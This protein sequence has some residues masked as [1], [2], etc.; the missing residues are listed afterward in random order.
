MF[1]KLLVPMK[2]NYTFFYLLN[3]FENIN[4][5]IKFNKLFDDNFNEF[6]DVFELLDK[7]EFEPEKQIVK[8]II[9]FSKSYDVIK[10]KSSNVELNLN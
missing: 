9:D 10:L 5:L 7:A 2:K 1:N 8:K 6:C 3:D 4:E